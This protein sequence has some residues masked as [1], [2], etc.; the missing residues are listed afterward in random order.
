M[1]LSLVYLLT[2]PLI[3]GHNSLMHEIKDRKEEYKHWKEYHLPNN[4]KRLQAERVYQY[5]LS[6]PNSGWSE[7]EDARVELDSLPDYV[8]FF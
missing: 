5:L 3:L 2:H 4:I 8:E 1:S 7:M 6:R